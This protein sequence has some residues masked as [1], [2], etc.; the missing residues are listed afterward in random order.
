[1]ISNRKKNNSLHPA[2]YHIPPPTSAAAASPASAL[3]SMGTPLAPAYGL[4]FSQAQA[5][6]TTYASSG[7]QQAEELGFDEHASYRDLRR[8]STDGKF[9]CPSVESGQWTTWAG[10][11]VRRRLLLHATDSCRPSGPTCALYIMYDHSI[12]WSNLEG[13]SSIHFPSKLDGSQQQQTLSTM[14]LK[15]PL[16]HI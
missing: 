9:R 11:I 4:P 10:S 3:A 16:F 13:R 6:A 7:L 5:H 12:H 14:G 15:W 1:M 8:W 2:R